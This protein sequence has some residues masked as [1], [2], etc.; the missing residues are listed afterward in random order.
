[1]KI[2]A[3]LGRK[4]G[5]GKTMTAHLLAHGLSK[6]FGLPVNIVMTDVREEKPMNFNPNRDYWISSIS[7]KDVKTDLEELDRIFVQTSKIPDSVLVIDGGANRA[8][9]DR[10][11]AQLS[12]FIMI[13]VAYGEEDI[14][15]AE[16]DFWNLVSAMKE[17]DAPGDICI[18]RNRWPG[19]GRERERLLNKG[20]VK[21][22]MDKAERSRMLFPDFIPDMPSLLDMANSNDPKTTPLIDG[23]SCRFAEVVA[24]KVG[25]VLPPR[26]KL[27][28]YPTIAE[29]RKQEK[30]EAA[31]RAASEVAA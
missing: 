3:C 4:G 8:N 13:P 16:S 5:S 2:I 29:I 17:A 11:F 20:W 27:I 7:N 22:F 19:S 23:V 18:I 10:A 1:M 24:K 12:D 31:A 14:K 9:V 28:T 30:Q 25:I 15:V 6:G 26:R 21:T